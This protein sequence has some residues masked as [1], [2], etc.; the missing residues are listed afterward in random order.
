MTEMAPEAFLLPNTPAQP[1]ADLTT[2]DPL[3][4]LFAARINQGDY[5]LGDS[6][7]SAVAHAV[8]NN[9]QGEF[10]NSVVTTVPWST[11]FFQNL[12]SPDGPAQHAMSMLGNDFLGA[13]CSGLLSEAIYDACE[14]DVRDCVN[15]AAA[16]ARCQAATDTI[17]YCAANWLFIDQYGAWTP[18]A[19]GP[20]VSALVQECSG[21]WEDYAGHLT[22]DAYVTSRIDLFSEG[23]WTNRSI[24]L[25][26]HWTNLKQLGAEP[27]RINETITTAIAMGLPVPPALA[28]SSPATTIATGGLADATGFYVQVD[29]ADQATVPDGSTRQLLNVN[30]QAPFIATQPWLTYLGWLDATSTTFPLNFARFMQAANVVNLTTSTTEE[31]PSY[32]MPSGPGQIDD[33]Y[34]RNYIEQQ[35]SLY[36]APSSSSCLSG[37]AVII[38]ADLETGRQFCKRLY[39]LQPGDMVLTPCGFREV[40][41]VSTPRRAGRTLHHI[42]GSEFGLTEAHP[43]IAALAFSD[44]GQT[45]RGEGNG[46][47]YAAVNPH[48]LTRRIPTIADVGVTALMGASV[49][50]LDAA[51][52]SRPRP[53][54]VDTIVGHMATEADEGETLYDVL[55]EPDEHGF[56]SY[57]AGDPDTLYLVAPEVPSL[58]RAGHA[59]L[60]LAC[61]LEK[62]APVLAPLLY[63]QPIENL[64]REVHALLS[65]ISRF[66]EEDAFASLYKELDLDRRAPHLTN[67]DEAEPGGA[68]ASIIDAIAGTS[69]YDPHLSQSFDWLSARYGEQLR[70]LISTGWR[71]LPGGTGTAEVFSIT[72]HDVELDQPRVESLSVA[73]TLRDHR[74]TLRGLAIANERSGRAETPWVKHPDAPLQMEGD[75]LRESSNKAELRFEVLDE[76]GLPLGMLAHAQVPNFAYSYCCLDLRDLDGVTQGRLRYD[77]R[78]L[79]EREAGAES[80][81]ASAW[82]S[83]DQAAFA[84]RLGRA[85]G[86]HIASAISTQAQRSSCY[87]PSIPRTGGGYGVEEGGR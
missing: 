73:A 15:K 31:G 26:T 37:N 77:I 19:G 30:G 47:A 4:N 84:I 17:A 57:F 70:A 83:E 5:T 67:G 76:T 71:Q 42:N 14:D 58:E 8:A 51:A 1:P 18:Y 25:Y 35:G 36:N 3:L 23:Q 12:P 7:V 55:L 40:R 72:I 24:E 68:V 53:R 59:A 2:G 16:D 33:G 43:L 75:W 20:T 21:R 87:V 66:G 13:F 65:P 45:A 50:V 29:A 27:P 52:P 80:E 78:R 46:P 60:A 28:A 82:V 69:G 11:I 64:H 61:I 62:V 39:E 48:E 74:R 44:G 38:S 10:A 22:S 63:S 86:T 54:V 85:I 9:C 49:L 41:L 34:S 79:S 6:A 56:P 81:A 32:H